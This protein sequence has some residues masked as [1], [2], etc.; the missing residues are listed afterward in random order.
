MNWQEFDS[1]TRALA[2]KIDFKP[3]IVIAI[4]RGGL[5]PATILAKLL[6]VADMNVLCVA[7]ND[8]VPRITND[9]GDVAR[10]NILLV[11]D[12]IETGRTLIAGKRYLEE[13]GATVKTACLYTMPTSEI[14][15]DYSL[16]QV[17]EA[18]K[19]PW[20]S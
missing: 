19:F 14:T 20:N 7:R 4:V 6:K 18:M 1:E 16:K 5:I 10:K 11:E 8:G 2:R 17:E 9:V 13:S 12:M 15:P 3:D